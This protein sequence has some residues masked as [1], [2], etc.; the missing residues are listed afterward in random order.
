MT[1]MNDTERR[2]TVVHMADSFKRMYQ[3]SMPFDRH[4]GNFKECKQTL[5]DHPQIADIDEASDKVLW[6]TLKWA[7]V[8]EKAERDLLD[9]FVL[10]T[11]GH[12][13]DVEVYD[14]KTVDGEPDVQLRERGKVSMDSGQNRR[15]HVIEMARA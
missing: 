2:I 5:R 6:I 3:T 1:S 9:L 10:G 12:T 13:C 7:E 15:Y 11:T 4:L 14:R 8:S